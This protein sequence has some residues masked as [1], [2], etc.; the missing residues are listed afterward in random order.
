MGRQWHQLNHM[1]IMCTS[2]QMDNHI[3]SSSHKYFTGRMPFLMPNKQRQSTEGKDPKR[4][5]CSN[6]PVTA[7]FHVWAHCTYGWWCR[8]QDDPNGSP[9]ENWKR[10]PWRPRITLLNTIQWDLRVYNLTL[11]EAVDL[12]QNHALWRLMST[13]GGRYALLAVHARKRTTHTDTCS[14]FV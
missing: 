14:A 13:Y 11:N 6:N 7:S 9:P 5:P 12:A 4:T 2:L 10:P 8:C 1:Q 3:S